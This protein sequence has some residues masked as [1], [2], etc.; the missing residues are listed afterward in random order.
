MPP[1]IGAHHQCCAHYG[2]GNGPVLVSSVSC[3]GS[4]E[5]ITS[6]SY[7]NSTIDDHEND[8]GVKC[9]KGLTLCTVFAV[10]MTFQRSYS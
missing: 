7:S 3:S 10:Y 9:Q 6:C 1:T 8:V 5:N 4:E 2:K